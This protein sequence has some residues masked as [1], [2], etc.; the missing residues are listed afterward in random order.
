MATHHMYSE[1]QIRIL[2]IDDDADTLLF[3]KRVL[4]KIDSGMHVETIQD[5]LEVETRL[6]T[7]NFDCIVS[8]FVM[9]KLN[10]IELAKRIREKSDIPFIL[11]TGQGSEEVAE[12]AFKVG[13][14][15]YVRK[16]VS[17]SHFQ[18][19]AKRIRSAVE[20]KWAINSVEKNAYLYKTLFDALLDEVFLIDPFT[21]EIKAANRT[22]LQRFN[23]KENELI[24][25]HCY[26]VTHGK[27]KPCEDEDCSCPIFELLETGDSVKKI[28]THY[29]SSNKPFWVEVCK[30][31]QGQLW[32]DSRGCP[33]LS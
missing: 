27:E 3:A 20:R 11:Y 14:N 2:H 13:V 28:H 16:E 10:G 15:D 31:N 6:R 1:Q 32:E 12:E 7:G 30:P 25:K 26:S 8:D 4:E 18:V 9:P 17:A 21:F 5:P 22:S 33:C 19:L 24:G 29:D 23:L